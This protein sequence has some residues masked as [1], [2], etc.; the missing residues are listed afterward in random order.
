MIIAYISHPDCMLHE[1]GD[2]HPEQPARLNAISD[3][4]ISSG[5]ETALQHYDAP[6]ASRDQ[7][8]RVHGIEYIEALYGAAPQQDFI[9]LDGDT[10]MNPH[11]LGAAL[12]AAGSACLAVDLLLENNLQ[13]AFCA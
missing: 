12:R 6:Q 1:M 13:R 4:L 10:A 8:L 7:L 11:T 9:W 2:S 5:L 3:R